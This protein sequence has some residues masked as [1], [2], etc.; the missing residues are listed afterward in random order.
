MSSRAI[1]IRPTM[2]GLF[3]VVLF[4]LQTSAAWALSSYADSAADVSGSTGA[5]AVALG[6]PDYRFVNDAGIGFAGNTDVFDVGESAVFT[7]ATPLRAVIGQHDLVISAYVGGLGE[8]DN[9]LVQVEVSSDGTN[10]TIVDSFDTDEARNRSQDQFENDFA[11]VKHFWIDFAGENDVTHVRLTNLAGTAEGF[12]LDSVEGLQPTIDAD[13][14]FEIRFERYRVDASE[15]FLIRLKNISDDTTGQAIVGFHLEKQP[16]NEWMEDTTH[17]LLASDGAGEMLCVD[18]CVGDADE[19]PGVHS[20]TWAFSL[21]GLVPAPA[22]VGLDPGI[23]ASHERFRNIDIDALGTYLSDFTFHVEFADGVVH[24]FDYDNDVQ[25]DIGQ[26]YQKYTYYSATPSLSGPRQVDYY[27]WK[28]RSRITFSNPATVGEGHEPGVGGRLFTTSQV[29]TEDGMHVE[30]FWIPN[31]SS[32]FVQGHFHSLETL[33][34]SSHGFE[35]SPGLG[36]DRQGFYI[37]RVDGGSFD[38]ES[39]DYRVGGTLSAATLLIS[40]TFDPSLPTAGQ[41]IEFPVVADPDFQTLEFTQFDDVTSIFIFAQLTEDQLERIDW[42]DLVIRTDD[43]LTIPPTANAGADIEVT[44]TDDDGLETVGLD[45]TASTDP[46]GTLEA[47]AW[48]EDGL[49]LG[50]GA[51]PDFVFTLG[52][53]DVV[54]Q[55]LDDDGNASVDTVQVQVNPAGGL[56]F[57]DAGPNQ[58]LVADGGGNAAVTLDGTDSFDS[59]GTLT[60]WD[61]SEGGVPLGSGE[62]L[63]LSLSTGVHVIELMV[64]DDS[65]NVDVDSVTISVTPPGGFPPI[66]DAGPNVTVTDVDTDGF[67]SVTLDASGSSDPDGTIISWDWSEGGVPLGSGETLPVSFAVGVHSVDLVVQDDGGGNA[68]DTV[69]ITVDSGI[70]VQPPNYIAHETSAET[71]NTTSHSLGVASLP[72][73]AGDLLVAHFCSDGAS[74]MTITCP[75]GFSEVE[76]RAH[77]SS[78]VY[79]ALCIKTADASDEIATSYEITT[80]SSQQSQSGVILLDS[81][82]AIDP[83]DGSAF[84]GN[85]SDTSPESPALAVAPLPSSRILRFMCANA[86]QVTEGVG[87]PSGM[88]NDLWVEETGNGFSGPVSGGAAIDGVGLTTSAEWTNALATG[89]QSVNFTLA[90]AGQAAVLMA[91]AGADVVVTDDDE[92]GSEDVTLDGSGSSDFGGSIVAWRWSEGV[93]ALGEGETLLVSFGEGVHDVDLEVEDDEGNLATDSVEISVNPGG[94]VAPIADAGPDQTVVDTDLGGTESVMLDGS[95]SSDAD[96]TVVSWTW[97]EGGSPVTTGETPL[98]ELAVGVHTIDLLVVDDDGN[99]SGDSVVITIQAGGTP[100]VADA[101]PD[102]SVSDADVTGSELVLLDGSGSFDPDGTIV[103]WTWTEGGSPLAGGVSPQVDLAIGTHTIDLLVVDNDGSSNGDSVVITVTAGGT[104][105]IADAGPTQNVVDNDTSGS[106]SVTLDGSGSSDPD[107]TIVRWSWTEN[108]SPLGEGE[109]IQVDLALGSHT[110]D[111]EIEDNHG[112]LAGD[113]VVITVTE[114][115]ASVPAVFLGFETSEE[116]SNATTHTLDVGTLPITTGD[117]LIA[118]I[119]VDGGGGTVPSCPIGWTEIENAASVSSGVLGAICIHE[120][121]GADEGIASYEFVTSVQQQSQSSVYLFA[122]HDSASPIEASAQRGDATGTS[123]ESPAFGAPP[124]P[125]SAVLRMMCANAGQATEGVGFPSGMASNLWLLESNEGYSGPVTGGGALDVLGASSAAVWSSALASSQQTI[126]FS[127]AIAGGDGAPIAAAGADVILVDSDEDGFENV[128]LDGSSSFDPNGSIVAWTWSD[129]GGLLGTGEMLVLPLIVGIHDIDLQVEDDEGNL[130]TDSVQITIIAGGAVPPV[131][132]AGSN[133]SVIDSDEDGFET[134]QLDGSASTDSD[135]SIVAWTWNEGLTEITTGETPLVSFAIGTHLVDL[136]VEDDDGNTDT[137]SVTVTV[138]PGGGASYVAHETSF[139]DS[140]TTTHD[141]GV[142]SLP[143]AAGD[144]LLAHV[145]IDGG[146]ST[147]MSCPAGWTE[148]ENRS[149][150]SSG[151]IGGVCMKQA[152]VSDETAT[153]YSISTTVNQHSQSGVILIEGHDVVA[154]IAEV[155][156]SVRERSDSPVSPALSVVPDSTSLVLRFVCSNTGQ[157]TEGVGFPSGTANDLWVLESADGN[158][159]P[160]SGGATIDAAG[161]SGDATWTSLL[162]SPQQSVTFSV[163]IRADGAP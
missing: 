86:G 36:P 64:S 118:Q 107:G 96:G 104:P 10:F 46:D 110:I 151:V 45:A 91:N 60:S 51:M 30:A 127:L 87:F 9:A 109:S 78:G 7:F 22:G 143:I 58:N 61:W 125:T 21:D 13:H 50:T 101:G 4:G 18:N 27:E 119:C 17:S 157:V 100:P 69:T 37:E 130:A 115:G 11:G 98:V 43:P 2:F 137:A 135:G 25:I 39:L 133:A 54:L 16:V 73:L 66:A 140:N 40:P 141:L 92:N 156:A 47:Y 95:A 132:D 146:G 26:L 158:S 14:A 80:T 84:R 62:T 114:P 5:A 105:P 1:R 6:V 108:G 163:T 83:V 28:N 88:Q 76:R 149:H 48:S 44:D 136:V 121:T 35:S 70:V 117:L 24:S 93:T 20:A 113:S 152:D 89:Q 147:A 123:P 131:A 161:S 57:A 103:S 12:R 160:V 106:E 59:D 94:L 32:D 150:Q 126:G 67:E 38:L 154:P 49:A 153:S 148:I 8:T 139:E 79:G 112:L 65:A 97:T 142:A 138:S 144:L 75:A 74:N 42:D 81:H 72:I 145:C 68:V 120:A 85:E 34:E 63:A 15:R 111:L 116:T 53:H 23:H 71:S 31:D 77:A 55:V 162:A 99:S 56:P 124:S 33:F 155:V 102:Q 129:G 90:I 122:G 41:V 82:D 52:R 3:L 29:F 159:G 128:V 19:I 134:I